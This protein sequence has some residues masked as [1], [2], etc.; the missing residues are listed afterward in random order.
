MSAP[1][2][3]APPVS[4]FAFSPARVG[5]MVARYSYLLRGSS[6][7]AALD[8]MYWPTVQLVTW[9]FIQRFVGGA[10]AAGGTQ[11]KLAVGAGT[12]IGA[13]MLWDVLFRGQL[14]FSL[15]F[16]EE[17]HSRNV[18]NLFMS[19]LRPLEFV[20]SLM[21]MSL[22]RLALGVVPV[23][24]LA[25][26]F[27]GFNLWGLGL[28]LGFFFANLMLTS[29]S[30]GPRGVGLPAAPRARRR[31]ARLELH[32][33]AA[34]A[35][36]RLLPGRR[37]AGLA[38]AARL[39][40]APHL[41]VRGPAGGA[42][43]RDGAH[44][45][46]GRRRSP[47]TPAS[48]AAATLA[49][50]WFLRA[51]RAAGTLLQMGCNDSASR[52]LSAR[53]RD[54]RRLSPL[55]A[56]AIFPPWGGGRPT[57]RPGVELQPLVCRGPDEDQLS[58][59]RDDASRAWPRPVPCPTRRACCSR[60]RSTPGPYTPLGRNLAASAEIFERM[61]RRYGKPVF[62][63]DHTTVDGRELAVTETAVWERPFCKLLHF[64]KHDDGG[65]APKSRMMVVAPLSGH[66]ATLLRAQRGSAAA[67]TS[68]S[69]SPTGP[70]PAWCHWRSA[71]STSTTTS[72]TSSRCC[73]SWAGT[74]C[75]STRWACASRRCR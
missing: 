49:F 8:L 69:T 44:R 43:R 73:S 34:A 45:P 16:L 46:D 22:V 19:P 55:A 53:N 65:T 17:M 29:W 39:G 50:L 75:R 51:S 35:L 63:L 10:A 32:V 4:R 68:T 47:S 41:R 62:G 38:A 1:R 25:I 18:G 6:A 58:H 36:L 26:L 67:R 31:G 52:P 12:L 54:T 30:V 9:G 23:T 66:Y 64:R 7:A 11:G 71:S 56:A 13:V 48:S 74:G 24:G 60:T 70:M 59:V 27:F 5:A 40:A 33:P 21:V 15:S 20:A 28:A 42:Q 14:G 72:A 2:S 57:S 3:G 37:A 61:T